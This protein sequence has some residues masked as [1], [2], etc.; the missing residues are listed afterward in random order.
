MPAL[1]ELA[2]P[3]T[4]ADVA[5]QDAA[6]KSIRRII[7]RGSCACKYAC[8]CRWGSRAWWITGASGTGK[9]TLAKLIAAEGAADICIEE[10]TAGDMTPAAVRELE[11]H[12]RLRPLPIDGKAGWCMI[13]NECHGLRKDTVKALL[14]A[15]ERIP[16]HVCWVFTTT[17]QGQA[18]FFDDD[19]E[20]D[21]A[22][23]VSRCI[24]V[25][26]ADGP[27]VRQALARRAH[28][29]AKANGMDGL[30]EWAYEACLERLGG[31]LRAV[32]QRI[33]AGQVA[34]VAR[35]ELEAYLR[36]PL[37]EQE[38]SKRALLQA[39]LAE[40]EGK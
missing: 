3:R 39:R 14:D 19:V 23:L 2:R 20:G 7:T 26:L 30:P 18:S 34:D 38:T 16:A 6:V 37:S 12:Y 32:L 40:L 29:V 17:N 9:T 4:W 35:E 10:H 24:V 13:V 15:L 27:S 21:A 25:K 28:A 33:E 5:G 8:T 22:P 11:R 31:N 1:F 36:L